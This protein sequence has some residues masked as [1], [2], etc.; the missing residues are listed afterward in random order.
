MPYPEEA[1]SPMTTDA[2]PVPDPAD[3]ARRPVLQLEQGCK[4]FGGTLALD[5]VSFDLQ[6]GSVH[7]L[8]GENGAGKSTLIKVLTGVHHLDEGRMRLRGE[9]VSFGRPVEAQ[10]AGISTIYQEVNLIPL[11]SVAANIF[12]GREP[13]RL[14]LVDRRRMER[15]AAAHLER[16]GI[17][18]DVRRPVGSLGLGAQQMVALARA[19]S[20]Q[21]DVVIMDEPT[22][23][24]EPREVATLFSVIERLHAEGIAIVYVSHRLDELYA[25]CDTVT[26]LRDGKRVHTG[27]LADLPRIEL[28]SMMLGREVGDIRR[29]GATALGASDR[30]TAPEQAEPILVADSLTSTGRIHDVSLQIRPGEVVGL[31]GLLGAGRSETAKTIIGAL[32]RDEGTVAVDGTPLPGGNIAAA[33]R[34]GVS[35]LAEDR[36]AEGIVPNLSIR[37]NI[38]LASLPALSRGGLVSRSKQDEVVTRLM[39]RLRIKASGPD[40]KV[41]ELS[42][43]NQQKVLL[44]RWLATSP[45]VLLLDEPTRGIDVGAKTEVQGL[46]D[47]LAADGLGVLLISSEIEELVDGADRVVVLRDGTAVEELA[48]DRVSADDILGAYAAAGEPSFEEVIADASETG[49]SQTTK[50]PR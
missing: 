16:L 19:V 13:T 5:H 26:V 10:R 3:P 49:T 50:E 24:L 43:G 15:E 9:E 33:M 1:I 18:V 20:T 29:H 42:G 41:V 39:D 21:A 31:A 25:V 4:R 47:E 28:V 30:E 22:S 35:M 38:A 34:A 46:I 23:S 11:R 40:Q 36:K 14:G 17:E 27:P 12:M 44:A 8:I 45:R 6:P 32:P 2:A 48:G 37:D 7:A